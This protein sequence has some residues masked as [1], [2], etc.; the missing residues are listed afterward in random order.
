MRRKFGNR[1][2]K[3]MD[4]IDVMDHASNIDIDLYWYQ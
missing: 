4:P 1:W 3:Y 2:V